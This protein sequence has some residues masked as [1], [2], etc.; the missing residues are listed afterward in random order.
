MKSDQQRSLIL[1]D[2]TA[3]CS[4]AAPRHRLRP[5]RQ[6]RR[7]RTDGRASRHP[8]HR[9]ARL[10]PLRQAVTQA[11]ETNTA[12]AST[13][14]CGRSNDFH[15]RD[16]RRPERRDVGGHR[17]CW[18]SPGVPVPARPGALDCDLARSADLLSRRSR[19]MKT[20]TCCSRSRTS[21][22][23]LCFPAIWR[24]Q[25]RSRRPRRNGDTDLGVR[26]ARRRRTATA[27]AITLENVDI[28]QA[29]LTIEC[30]TIF[31]HT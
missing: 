25:L 7:P 17:S 16:V 22:T 6:H 5:R 20:P 2:L 31:R 28:G 29:E 18:R 19:A 26:V 1:L 8:H 27:R 9:Q 23:R 13:T 12:T 4:T 15:A 3:A 11:T 21:L 14:P 30:G 24:H 10:R